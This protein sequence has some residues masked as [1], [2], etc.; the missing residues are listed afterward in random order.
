MLSGPDNG[1][2]FAGY[3]IYK[4][5]LGNRFLQHTWNVRMPDG[6]HRGI[7]IF[8]F[9]PGRRI[10]FAHAYDANGSLVSSQVAFRGN[11]I[12]IVSDQSSFEGLLD[13]SGSS[14]AGVWFTTEGAQPVMEV[15]LTS[16]RKT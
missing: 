6:L 13:R 11:R 9:D 1:K 12:R 15:S 8:G 14:I 5:L 16:T 7:E 10:I 3:D 2:T 4:W